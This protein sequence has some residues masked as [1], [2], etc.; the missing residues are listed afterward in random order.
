MNDFSSSVFCVVDYG[1]FQ[2]LAH[3]LARD[4]GKVYYV[5]QSRRGHP[6]ASDKAPGS[7][8]DDIE[9]VD[10]WI[11]LIGKVDCWVFPDLFDGD[12]QQHLVSLGQRVFGGRK[13]DELEI[14]R[15]HFRQILGA[16]GL[17]VNPYEV[18]H[19]VDELR[20]RLMEVEDKYIKTWSTIRGTTETWH[21]IRYN[22]SQ[23][24][25]DKISSGLG[26]LRESQEFLIDDPIPDVA[27]IGYDDFCV[28]GRFAQYG[29]VGIEAKDRAYFGCFMPYAS[30]PKVIRETNSKL[31]PVLEAYDYRSFW[32]TELRG[33]YLIDPCPRLASPAGE[34]IQEIN[35]NLAERIWG[36]AEGEVVQP[37]AAGRYAAQVMMVS[38]E[39]EGNPLPIDVPEKNRAWVKLYNSS[40]DENKQ[41]WVSPSANRMSELGSVVGIGATPE[42][43][44]K[45]CQDH[46]DG[47]QADGLEIHF[48]E[49]D[50][51]MKL[52]R[53]AA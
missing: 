40:L 19:G 48:T 45:A 33:P 5:R 32:S 14:Y 25:L 16:Q 7:G 36:A 41:E 49:L 21:H 10:G 3:R 1:I 2:S 26:S 8:Y 23:Q 42:A 15:S 37:I 12:I 4:V 24:H 31:A 34:C 44:R 6:L 9:L 47:I 46:A 53:K 17:P 52:V 28:Q 11:P 39:V 20:D 27:E 29:M 43:A 13:G 30:M 38:D 51:A 50:E 35:K 18:V 22:L